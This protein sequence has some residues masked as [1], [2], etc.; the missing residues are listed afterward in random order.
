MKFNLKAKMGCKQSKAVRVQPVGA[1][2]MPNSK[3]RATE[4]DAGIERDIRSGKA[5]RGNKRD[6]I[7]DGSETSERGGSAT[8]KKSNDSG[9]DDLGEDNHAFITEHS[10]PE[11]VR[12]VEKQFREHQDL[13]TLT[14]N[15][16]TYGAD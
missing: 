10:D 9:V 16:I 15:V 14:F 3:L 2:E 7:D 6:S 4:S 11:K 12:E 8:S 1:A 5:R 13:G